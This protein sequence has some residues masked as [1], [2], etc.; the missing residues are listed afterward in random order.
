MTPT[1][2]AV[3]QENQQ[4]LAVSALIAHIDRLMTDGA[5]VRSVK[6]QKLI[7]AVEASFRH[8]RLVVVG[9]APAEEAQYDRAL[10]VVQEIGGAD[11][12]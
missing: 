8:P 4:R 7:A 2:L 1:Q 3:S 9:D 6:L 12:G 10:D 5:L 11:R